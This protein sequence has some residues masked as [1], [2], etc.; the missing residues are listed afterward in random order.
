MSQPAISYTTA[1]IHERDH[2]IGR[3]TAMASPCEVLLDHVTHHEATELLDLAAAEAARIEHKFSR[4]RADSVVQHINMAGGKPITVDDETARLL[5]YA[6]ECYSIS[7]GMFDITSGVLRRVWK[8][9]GGSR[10]LDKEAVFA[11]L[12]LI[13][14]DKAKWDN[15]CITLPIGMEIDLGGIGKEYAVDT[16]AG[17]IRPRTQSSFVVNYGGDLYISGPRSNGERW[18]IG[19]D[20]PQTTGVGSVGAISAAR[21][22][23]ATSGDARRFLLKDGVRYCHILNPRSGWPIVGAPHS[24]TVVAET[25]LEAGILS[26]IAMLHGPE[27]EFFLKE[28]DVK[29]WISR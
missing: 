24:V 6:A 26:T 23:I 1:L 15:P 5:D 17:L 29:F 12:P 22:G 13:G 3:F 4:Y 18:M 8:F 19:V 28:Q 2:W 7:D 16:T 9:D 14:W 20:D 10:L 21:G 27:A 11:L 25:C